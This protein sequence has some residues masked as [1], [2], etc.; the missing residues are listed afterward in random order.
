VLAGYEEEMYFYE[1]GRKL[2]ANHNVY[3]LVR[4]RTTGSS[5][6]STRRTVP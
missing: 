2:A 4:P 3:G 6:R 1:N 5:L